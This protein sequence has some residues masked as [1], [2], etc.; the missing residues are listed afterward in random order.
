M[1]GGVMAIFNRC[2]ACKQRMVC[3]SKKPRLYEC[4]NP[5][6]KGEKKV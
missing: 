2:A 3:V 5:K 4:R 6:C 1:C